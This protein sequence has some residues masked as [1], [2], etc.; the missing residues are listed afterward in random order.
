[1]SILIGLMIA[2]IGFLLVWK[3]EWLMINFGRIDW[4]EKHLGTEGGTRIFYKLG[5]AIIILFGYAIMTGVLQPI[6]LNVLSPLFG[7]LK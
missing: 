5:G 4:A 1:M 2:A 3:T 6:L 7:G